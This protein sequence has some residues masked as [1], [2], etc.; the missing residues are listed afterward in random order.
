MILPIPHATT[1]F[2]QKIRAAAARTCYRW[3]M[4]PSPKA[5]PLPTPVIELNGTSVRAVEAEDVYFSAEGGLEETQHVFLSGNYLPQR[6]IGR[7]RFTVC[8]IG[9]GTGLNFLATW[10]AFEESV[11]EPDARLFYISVERA[12]LNESQLAQIYLQFPEL[13]PYAAHLA[14]RYPLRVPGWHRIAFD[15]VVLWL[16]FGDGLELLKDFRAEVDAWYLDGFAPAKNTEAW[17]APLFDEIARLSAADASFATFSAAAEVKHQAQRAGF[18]VEKTPGFGKKRDMLRGERTGERERFALIVPQVA[19]I[20]AGI[21][22]SSAAHALAE[23]GAQVSLFD[24]ETPAYG[25]SGNPAAVLYP[26]LG[27]HYSPYVAESFLAYSHALREIV[28]LGGYR[29]GWA[30]KCGMVKYPKSEME[31]S[32]LYAIAENLGLDESVV[33]WKPFEEISRLLG[34]HV[35]DGGVWFPHGSWLKPRE[36]TRAY[37]DHGRVRLNEGVRVDD[38]EPYGEGFLIRLAQGAC[39]ATHVVFAN[40]AACLSYSMCEHLPLRISTGQ[41]SIVP[42]DALSSRPKAIFCH[43]GY[44]IMLEEGL[45]I[46]ATYDHQN[47]SLNLSAQNHAQNLATLMHYAPELVKGKPKLNRGRIS[48]RVSAPDKIPLVGSLIGGDGAAVA[49][50]YTSLGHASRG[51]ISAPYAA[52]KIAAAIYNEPRPLSW[53]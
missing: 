4:I 18:R 22:G 32:R 38:V 29:F 17:S 33:S 23:R 30:Q 6:W 1:L 11:I 45:L 8:E 50:A 21:A 20:G 3:G 27:K 46:G 2:L 36:Y 9:F 47:F 34:V 48:Y 31:R 14:A 10:K 15:R 44:A 28:R 26:K 52:E 35:A 25:A 39:A 12:P 53:E 16:G 51:M 7:L 37:A 13:A 40:A 19:V 24:A 43:K 49:G 5:T 42:P 41:V